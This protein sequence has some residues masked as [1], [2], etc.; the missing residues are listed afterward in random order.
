MAIALD[1]RRYQVKISFL[2]LHRNI[3]CGCSLEAPYQGASNEH[4]QDMFS[5]KNK[6]NIDTFG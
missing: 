1:K 3:C 6:K 5:W 4:S 2:F